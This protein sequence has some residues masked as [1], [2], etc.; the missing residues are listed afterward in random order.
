MLDETVIVMYVPEP[1]TAT[2]FPRHS[3]TSVLPSGV[4]GALEIWTREKLLLKAVKAKGTSPCRGKKI[5]PCRASNKHKTCVD[6]RA[7]S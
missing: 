5:R 3:F 4:D 1:V 2:Q 7:V 6:D